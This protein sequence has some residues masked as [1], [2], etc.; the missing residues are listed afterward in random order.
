MAENDQKE[1]SDFKVLHRYTGKEIDNFERFFENTFDQSDNIQRKVK[2]SEL[3][4][5]YE[6][7]KS[8]NYVVAESLIERI[9]A[10][11]DL[12]KICAIYQ[13][14]FSEI[15]QVNETYLFERFQ[16]YGL[17]IWGTLVGGFTINRTGRDSSFFIQVIFLAIDSHYQGKGYGRYCIEYLQKRYKNIALYSD[18]SSIIFYEKLLFNKDAEFEKVLLMEGLLLEKDAIFMKWGF[19]Q[20][21][22]KKPKIKFVRSFK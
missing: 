2:F 6:H 18:Y 1:K 8:E 19:G 7:L 14:C 15:P 9:S 16:T 22:V 20:Y 11:K 5:S 21:E 12:Q 13:R 4:K 10:K 3:I 17:Y